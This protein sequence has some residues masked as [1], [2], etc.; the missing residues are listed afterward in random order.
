MTSELFDNKTIFSR[1]SFFKKVIS[2]FKD[3]ADNFNHIAEVSI[4]TLANKMDMSY[5]FYIEHNLRVLEWQLNELINK[6]KN[7]IN[8]L[9]RNWRHPLIRK[10]ESYLV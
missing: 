4:I 1:S 10:F 8:N 9:K 7:L 3:K 5:D 2:D 6:D